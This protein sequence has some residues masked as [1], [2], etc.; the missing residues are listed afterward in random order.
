MIEFIM[1]KFFHEKYKIDDLIR[2]L[3]KKKF[4]LTKFIV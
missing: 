2:K 1:N 3:F 4:V